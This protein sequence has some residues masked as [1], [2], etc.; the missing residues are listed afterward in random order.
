G[1]STATRRD[2]DRL[3]KRSR[4]RALPP[5][6]LALRPVSDVG[7]R[8]PRAW[9]AGVVRVMGPRRMLPADRALPAHAL[10]NGE[11]DPGMGRT[12]T[13]TKGLRRGS[14]PRGCGA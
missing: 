14:A 2:P 10:A 6:I 3:G 7:A 1:D 12:R 4:P 11:P 13:K 9:E 5:D 8:R